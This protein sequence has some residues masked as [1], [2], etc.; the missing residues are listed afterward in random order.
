LDLAGGLAAAMAIFL[1][2]QFTPPAGTTTAQQTGVEAAKTASSS[3]A[4]TIAIA[5]LPFQNLSGAASQEFFSD[6][7]TEEITSVIAK[8]ADLRVLGRTSAFQFKGEKKTC[9]PSA[10]P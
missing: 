6:G 5:V 9:A 1:Y 2:Y 8:I 7:I 3:L 4:G 10:K